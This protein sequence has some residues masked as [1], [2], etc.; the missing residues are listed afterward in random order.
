MIQVSVF[1][2]R[3]RTRGIE[4]AKANRIFR[5]T[6]LHHHFEELAVAETAIVIRFWIAAALCAAIALLWGRIA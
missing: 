2:L 3:K 5:R 6:P 4:Y 1:K